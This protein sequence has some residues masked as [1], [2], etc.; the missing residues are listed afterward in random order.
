M[1]EVLRT[2]ESDVKNFLAASLI[3]LDDVETDDERF[4][5]KV[6]GVLDTLEP[7]VRRQDAVQV[8]TA[9]RLLDRISAPRATPIGSRPAHPMPRAVRDRRNTLLHALGTDP[10]RP[11]ESQDGA[12]EGQDGPQ[13]QDRRSGQQR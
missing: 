7:A 2:L 4:W 11:R 3:R 5:P 13:G 9:A 10:P 1:T 12:D 6:L 8:L